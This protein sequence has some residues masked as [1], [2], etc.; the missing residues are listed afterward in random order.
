MCIDFRTLNN[1]T[2][3]N[4]YPLPFIDMLLDAVAGKEMFSFCDGYARFH[5]IPMHPDSVLKTTFITPRI[6]A[7]TV[8]LFGLEGGPG[9][10]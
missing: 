9:R 10:Y 6:F 2:L 4:R 3:K 1:A 8:M 7:Y 5:R